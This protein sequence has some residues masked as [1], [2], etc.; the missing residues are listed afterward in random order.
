MR[1]SSIQVYR[2]AV[3]LL[4]YKGLVALV[5]FT[6]PSAKSLEEMLRTDL[7]LPLGEWEIGDCGVRVEKN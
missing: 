1:L 6:G 3:Q 5:K 7:G 4:P 2:I